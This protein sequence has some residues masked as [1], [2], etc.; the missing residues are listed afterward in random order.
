MRRCRSPTS[1]QVGSRTRSVCLQGSP[2]PSETSPSK[3]G[4]QGS[5]LPPPARHAGAVARL[6]APRQ[7][8]TCESNAVRAPY[9]RVQGDQPVVIRWRAERELN[10]RAPCCR[11]RSSP[12]NRLAHDAC[13]LAKP[14]ERAEGLA[15]SFSVWKT[16]VL[17]FGRCPQAWGR[18]PSSRVS[19]RGMKTLVR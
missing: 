15:P 8:I 3:C 5:H 14:A 4:A 17:L 19:T 16:V 2:L 12:E 7:W 10:P 1:G 6:P 13:M 18:A 11:R 9:Q